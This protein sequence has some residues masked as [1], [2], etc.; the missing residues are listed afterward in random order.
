VDVYEIVR[1][2][3]S[4]R[5]AA[6]PIVHT[7]DGSVF[8]Y[9]L[10]ARGIKGGALETPDALFS[11]ARRNNVMA[12]IDLVCLRRCIE[13]CHS[14]PKGIRVDVNVYPS[15]LLDTRVEEICD[16]LARAPACQLVLELNE[17]EFIG[18]PH[19][20]V[21][22]LRQLRAAGILIGLDDIG[23]GR[24]SF[25]TLLTVEP[26]VV[27]I[28]R[29]AVSGLAGSPDRRRTLR[30]MLRCLESLGPEVIAEGVETQAD[31]EILIAM[32]VHLAQGFLWG[33][34]EIV[35][36]SSDDAP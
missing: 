24:S 33:R 2:P 29:G 10:L 34:P 36:P 27:K 7:R 15:T 26:D 6:Q 14:L 18:D 11:T 35:L 13:A 12:A 31:A 4:V 16:I 8:G 5:V 32:G 22:K 19:L 3:A 17:Q 21:P 1:R 23:F 30:R 25:E 20:I 9:E 28:D